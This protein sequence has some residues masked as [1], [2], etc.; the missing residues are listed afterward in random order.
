MEDTSVEAHLPMLMKPV[1]LDVLLRRVE[2]L[3]A[4]GR[5]GG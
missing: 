1:R 4:A 2:D 3:L 5:A